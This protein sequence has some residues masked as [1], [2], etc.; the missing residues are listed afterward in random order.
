MRRD[1]RTR[2]TNAF[3]RAARPVDMWTFRYTYM[4]ATHMRD[5]LT[6]TGRE[7]ELETLIFEARKLQDELL[8]SEDG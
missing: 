2:R 6:R 3:A 4:L 8:A 7:G 5:E 1:R